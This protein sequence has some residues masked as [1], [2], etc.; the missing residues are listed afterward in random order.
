MIAP[1][2]T[3]FDNYCAYLPPT[4]E[5]W[6]IV[7]D[8][9]FHQAIV[10][11]LLARLGDATLLDLRA[12]PQA[13]REFAREHIH[14][15]RVGALEFLLNQPAFDLG[16]S[17]ALNAAIG[18]FD[19]WRTRKLKLAFEVWDG[20]FESLFSEQ[21]HDLRAR[22]VDMH[23]RI[24]AQKQLSCS[25][26]GGDSDR[27]DIQCHDV[28]WI[29]QTGFESYDY[30]LPTGEV[31]TCPNSL[32]G[33]VSLGG[34]LIGT[35]P[36]GAKYGRVP[37]GGIVLRFVQ[38]QIAGVTGTH[39]ELCRDFEAVLARFPTLRHASEVGV[40]MSHAVASAA[41][42]HAAGHLW[43]ERH[44]GCHIGL[45]ARIPQTPHPELLP[46][47]PHLDLVLEHGALHAADGSPLLAW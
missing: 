20:N 22:C 40:G 24:S 17:P 14:D 43:H 37:P 35:L 46:T 26:A 18:E 9:A 3:A 15:D 38:G 42:A 28:V 29:T 33:T 44:V 1:G 36:F 47:G 30:I 19:R 16:Y 11:G 23:A 25:A 4:I 39:H 45:G 5:H 27:L 41:R 34:W 21:S 8:G 6:G 7:F 2:G 31:A 10:R 13:V 12:G 32:E